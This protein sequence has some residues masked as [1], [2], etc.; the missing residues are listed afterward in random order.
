M[1][2]TIYIDNAKYHK[3]KTQPAPKLN[4]PK[5]IEWMNKENIAYNKEVDKTKN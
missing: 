4:K 1:E 2:A 3:T 5:L